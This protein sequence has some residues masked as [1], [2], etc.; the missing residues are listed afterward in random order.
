MPRVIHKTMTM[1]ENKNKNKNKKPLNKKLSEHPAITNVMVIHD[2]D[3]EILHEGEIVEPSPNSTYKNHLE[4][5]R[6]N[7]PK[8]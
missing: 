2:D 4:A 3:F 1:E 8:V 7:P 6:T 5:A